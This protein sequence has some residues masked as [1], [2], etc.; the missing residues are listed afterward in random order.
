MAIARKPLGLRADVNLEIRLSKELAGLQ[1]R[2]L[3]LV[4]GRV[5]FFGLCMGT[6]ASSHTAVQEPG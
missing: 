4:D 6:D 3:V 1:N 2:V 5:G